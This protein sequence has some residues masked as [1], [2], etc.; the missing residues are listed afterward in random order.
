MPTSQD[1]PPSATLLWHYRG[2]PSAAGR[3]PRGPFVTARYLVEVLPGQYASPSDAIKN[4]IPGLPQYGDLFEP[5]GDFA[6]PCRLVEVV[7]NLGPTRFIAKAFF[8]YVNL[9][10]GGAARNYRT[11]I[12]T[13]KELVE[14]PR[15]QKSAAGDNVWIPAPRHVERHITNTTYVGTAN[16][17]QIEAIRQ[18]IMTYVGHI[19]NIGG[20]WHI[21]AGGD[22]WTDHLNATRYQAIF[23]TNSYL[24][25]RTGVATLT[26]APP[27]LPLERWTV[28]LPDGTNPPTIGKEAPEDQYEIIPGT[29][30]QWIEDL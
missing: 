13:R 1:N 3:G 21:F 25:G 7:R 28:T 18:E 16:Q 27:L 23:E 11:T 20:F 14:L 12:N 9:G 8:G 24:K 6:V 30:L 15:Y 4:P 5:A 2:E 10:G 19:L 26:G 29:A 22:V 17:S